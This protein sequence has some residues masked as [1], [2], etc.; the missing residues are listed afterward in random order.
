MNKPTVPLAAYG[1]K[2]GRF[3]R[4]LLAGLGSVFEIKR[5]HVLFQ[6]HALIFV[7]ASRALAA[8][9]SPAWAAHVW[10]SDDGLPNNN[11]TGL[12]Q[13]PDGYLWIANPGQLA[14]FDG[15]NFEAFPSPSLVGL[16][17]KVTSLLCSRAGGLW[18]GM[19][20]GRLVYLDG[21]KPRIFVT[22][23]LLNLTASAL[24]EDDEGGVWIL[25]GGNNVCRF[26]DGQI[27]KFNKPNG[28]PVSPRS[29]CSLARDNQ[30][31]IWLATA[32]ELDRFHDGRFETIL[33]IATPAVPVRL[34]AARA[35]GLWICA[36]LQLFKYSAVADEK[37]LEVGTLQPDQPSTE[38]TVLLEDRHGAVWIGTSSSGLFRYDASDG[39]SSVP[40]SHG[41]ILSLFEDREGY[42]WVGTG[43]G[44]LDRIQPRAIKV[45]DAQAGLPMQAVQSVCEDSSGVMWATTEN[46]LLT[47]HQERGDGALISADANWPGGRATCVAAD[48]S[49]AVWIGTRSRQLLCWRDGR[50]TILGGADGL[51][52]QVIHALLA[53]STGDLW[54]AGEVPESLQR[55]RAGHLQTFTLPPGIRVIRAMAEDTSGNIWLGTSKGVLLRVSGDQVIDETPRTTG[56]PLSVRC[57]HATADG[58]VWIGYVGGGVGRFKNGRFFRIDSSAGLYDDVISQIIADGRGWLW[59]G[60]DHGVFKVRQQELDD[61]AEGRS[62]RVRSI[63]YG[64]D[65]DL[66]SLQANFGDSPGSWRSHDGRLWIPMRTGV[67]VVDPA[68]LREDPAPPFILLNRLVVDDRTVAYYGGVVPVQNM[69]D[70]QRPQAPLRLEPG[71]RRLEFE[72]TALTFGA[73][74]NVHFR[75]RLEGIDDGWIEAETQRSASYSRLPAGDYR[76]RVTACNGDGIWNETGATLGFTVA[77][78]F[79]LTWWFRL[80]ALA[81]FTSGAVG[82]GRYVSFRRLHLRLHELEQKAALDRERARIARDIHDDLGGSLTQTI[83]LLD[84]IR[85]NSA[86]SGQVEEYAR[87]ISSSARQVIQSL[88]EIVWAVNPANDTLPA[89]VDYIG[90]FAAGFLQT[91]NL[92]CRLDLPDVLPNRQLA[93]EVRHNLFLVLKEALNNI[94]RHAQASEI[95]LSLVVTAESLRMDIADNGRGFDHA[96]DLA[97]AD[98]LRN[99]RRRMEEIGGRCF[100]ESRPETGTIVSVSFPWPS[101]DREA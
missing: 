90:H 96:P 42:I 44:G 51:P 45:E 22:N 59:F 88:D 92:R 68:K 26:K 72:F 37:P 57:L 101:L 62:V 76:F 52:S 16:D 2:L 30:G 17:Y 89:F 29:G 79:W 78:F 14:R 10:Q 47:Y 99:M 6:R 43:G 41:A 83:L 20:H 93:P 65:D 50:F 19:D 36:G 46:G 9:F 53:S 25:Y 82:I 33:R 12:A 64:R 49:G 75:Y 69:V 34:A 38:P 61:V 55:L 84:L 81:L 7:L 28:M 13:T 85:K 97:G 23:G 48:R 8:S 27:I 32:G 60:S 70:L 100:I 71:H 66:P 40:T 24:T 87:Q 86:D 15:V 56:A 58:S 3:R 11:V 94:V 4:G 74:E 21:K 18:L 1:P 67:A 98:G 73:A 35:G 63:H 91:A 31:R 95:R 54:I 5:H 80:S 39:L 77:P